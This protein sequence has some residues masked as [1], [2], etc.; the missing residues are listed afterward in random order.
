MISKFSLFILCFSL[1]ACKTPEPEEP[2]SGDLVFTDANNYSYVAD[3]QIGEFVV[4]T[5]TAFTVDWSALTVDLRGRTIED[6]EID[7]VT[8]SEFFLT[9]EDVMAKVNDNSLD[10]G[11]IAN[12][13]QY[14]ILDGETSANIEDFE[15]IGN[16]FDLTALEPDD[17]KSWLVSLIDTDGTRSLDIF[18]SKFVSPS[19]SGTETAHVVTDACSTLDFTADLASAQFLETGA[20]LGSYTLDFSGVENDANGVP[21]DTLLGDQLFIVDTGTN[22][23]DEIAD[24]LLKLFDIA[25][26]T[27]YASSYGTT[28]V[29]LMTA[30][31]LDGESFPG[32]TSGNYYVI[33]VECTEC[34]SPAPMFLGLVDV[35]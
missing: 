25:P 2:L 4:P 14:D 17:T 31:T 10:M 8:I 32:F 35:K 34:T 22:N 33:G 18:M 9:H 16:A 1:T 27:W 7:I 26:N 29:D 3:L 28:F 11:D 15:I 30:Q 20:E 19:D 5:Q 12:Y 6:G 13:F 21:Y 23:I 24:T